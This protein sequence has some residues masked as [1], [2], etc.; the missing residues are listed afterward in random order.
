MNQLDLFAPAPVA[1]KR[2]S[3]LDTA[4]AIMGARFDSFVWWC[5]NGNRSMCAAVLWR[6]G[7]LSPTIAAET[8]DELAGSNP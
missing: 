6:T 8:V 1:T 4:R 7:K 5:R 3:H 2:P